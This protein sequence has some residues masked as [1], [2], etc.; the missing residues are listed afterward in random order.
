MSKEPLYPHKP[1]SKPDSLFYYHG[2]S[3]ALYEQI[4]TA[5]YL[6][7]PVYV[8]DDAIIAREFSKTRLQFHPDK[9]ERG[10]RLV[11]QLD[12][13]GLKIVPD[14]DPEAQVG[15]YRGKLFMVLSPVATTRIKKVV[16]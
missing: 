11:L 7:A 5:G 9:S 13:T 15:K 12:L 4:K 1:K 14:A 3:P 10:K 8:A 16:E 6:K 2:T